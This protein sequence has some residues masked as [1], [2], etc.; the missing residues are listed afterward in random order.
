METINIQIRFTE[1]T[2]HG[3]YS[4]ALYY[5]IGFDLDKNRAEVEAE[6]QARVANWIQAI[7]NPAPEVEPTPEDIEGELLSLE[8]QKSAIET[9]IME[10]TEVLSM[11]VETL[12]VRK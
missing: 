1:D 12:A 4:D 10:K 3:T 8:A 2:S 11:S 7:E 9:L 5:P 6:K